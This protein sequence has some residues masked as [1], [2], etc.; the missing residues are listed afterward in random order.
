MHIGDIC[1]RRVV[2]DRDLVA[3][4]MAK[5]MEP[6]ERVVAVTSAPTGRGLHEGAH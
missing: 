6:G 3:E 2:T 4:I 1:T 5:A